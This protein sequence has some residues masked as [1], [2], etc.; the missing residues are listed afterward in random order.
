M[1]R[2]LCLF[3]K[4]SEGWTV[5]AERTRE[6]SGCAAIPVARKAIEKKRGKPRAKREAKRRK[7]GY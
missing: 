2:V 1:L 3:L 5:S 7:V 4:R 6:L